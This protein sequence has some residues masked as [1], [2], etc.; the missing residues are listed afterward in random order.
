MCFTR[1]ASRLQPPGL[2]GH[3]FGG[4]FFTHPCVVVMEFEISHRNPVFFTNQAFKAWDFGGCFSFF[5]S[6]LPCF[7]QFWCCLFQWWSVGYPKG[8]HS[9]DDV[10]EIV[11]IW[12][13][14]PCWISSAEALNCFNP[15]VC[16]SSDFQIFFLLKGGQHTPIS[17][18][19]GVPERIFL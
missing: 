3:F 9:Q 2:L 14:K 15:L 7:G 17:L 5:F 4:E 6:H 10:I 11:R 18:H 19:I 8:G 1:T 13:L 12:G 16:R